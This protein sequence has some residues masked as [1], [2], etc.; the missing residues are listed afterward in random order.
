MRTSNLKAVILAGDYRGPLACFT[1]SRLN[2]SFM[3]RGALNVG[4]TRVLD[5]HFKSL[6]QIGVEKVFVPYWAGHDRA[7]KSIFGSNRGGLEIAWQPQDR[8]FGT[9]DSMIHAVKTAGDEIKPS[10]NLLF[11]C[12]DIVLSKHDY[13]EIFRKMQY[14]LSNTDAHLV[15]AVNRV[16]IETIVSGGSILFQGLTDQLPSEYGELPYRSQEEFEQYCVN[17]SQ[18]YKKNVTTH[19]SKP[20]ALRIIDSIEKPRIPEE[21][22]GNM[23]DMSIY[24]FRS[25]GLFLSDVAMQRREEFDFNKHFLTEMTRM[26]RKYSVY[27]IIFSDG[28]KWHH[29]DSEAAL[30]NLDRSIALGKFDAGKPGEIFKDGRSGE[31][32]VVGENVTFGSRFLIGDNVTIE[33]G[34][35]IGEGSVIQSN[36]TIGNGSRIVN[37]TIANHGE[38][39]LR[40]GENSTVINSYVAVGIEPN[41]KIESQ[42]AVPNMHINGGMKIKGLRLE[43][44]RNVYP[45]VSKIDESLTKA[46]T[47]IWGSG[48]QDEESGC[49]VDYFDYDRKTDSYRFNYLYPEINGYGITTLLYLYTFLPDVYGGTEEA[50]KGLRDKA[51]KAVVGLE[52]YAQKTLK[53]NG[54][55]YIG[56]VGRYT[57]NPLTR[58]R[59]D[60]FDAGTELL[61]A[62]DNAMILNGL[63]NLYR[64]TR[65]DK[66]FHMAKEIVKLFKGI[67]K[68]GKGRYLATYDCLLKKPSDS[69]DKWSLHSG[70]YHSKLLIGLLNYYKR[71]NDAELKEDIQELIKATKGYQNPDTGRIVLTE[72]GQPTYMHSHLYS[73]EGL[74]VAGVLLNDKSALKAAGRAVEWTLKH[75]Y[76][77]GG[78]PRHYD[79]E[80]GN[81]SGESSDIIAQTLRLACALHQLR[82]ISDKIGDNS[83]DEILENL[84]NRLLSFQIK[85]YDPRLTAHNRF[86]GGFLYGYEFDKTEK[87]TPNSW[88]TMFAIQALDYYRKWKSHIKIDLDNFLFI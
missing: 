67:F 21:S 86:E 11:L 79:A 8:L 2:Q 76:E 47:F 75:Q 46:G 78:V 32:L 20:K 3:A 85:Y 1:D 80:S 88:C 56:Y 9:A 44:A 43:S 37:S 59:A 55:D 71:D 77:N 49:F 45:Y 58:L 62:F 81:V 42:A 64:L 40:I 25:A 69:H 53:Q 7:F 4:T 38:S 51:A 27:G 10:D 14:A 57:S 68:I 29:L 65:E 74:L 19:S 24:L 54:V 66:Y 35:H 50:R 48:I 17:V 22:F 41:S 60:S 23:Q 34:A 28:F 61:Y 82:F 31:N 5:F 13:S 84:K 6:Q 33:D 36:V 30:Y 63:M 70:G 12:S 26:S 73:A 15:M 87:N 72:A 39:R 18:F 83:I 52:K 16:P